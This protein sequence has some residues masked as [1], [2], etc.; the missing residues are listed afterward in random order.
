MQPISHFSGMAFQIMGQVLV[1]LARRKR[2]AKRSLPDSRITFNPS[3]HALNAGEDWI[4][5]IAN[6][7]DALSELDPRQAHIVE[8]RVFGGL[9]AEESAEALDLPVQTVRRQLHVAQA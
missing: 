5:R 1:D 2:S 8:M 4:I 7:I 3:L 9:T 6:A